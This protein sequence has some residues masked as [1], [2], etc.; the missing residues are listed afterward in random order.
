MPFLA[1]YEISFGEKYVVS[2]EENK[3]KFDSLNKK[4][5]VY[6]ELVSEF[7]KNGE[8]DEK[9]RSYSVNRVESWELYGWLIEEKTERL[10][11]R[12]LMRLNQRRRK[13]REILMDNSSLTNSKLSGYTSLSRSPRRSILLSIR[14]W[15]MFERTIW[16]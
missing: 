1:K 3:V 12:K 10:M 5:V 14:A 15:L 4:N 7:S 11:L 16:L 13:S 2:F 9:I 8:F 6:Y